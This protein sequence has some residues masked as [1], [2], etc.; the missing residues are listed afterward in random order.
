MTSEINNTFV[1]V[2][3][4]NR[5]LYRLS[6]GSDLWEELTNGLPADPVV[7]GVV[8][9]PDNPQVVYAGTQDGPYRSTDG[10]EN[11]WYSHKTV[12]GKWGREK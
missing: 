5:G 2:G 4:E 6:P 3:A 12:D 9:H 11:V 10:G 1:Y 8:L 7:P